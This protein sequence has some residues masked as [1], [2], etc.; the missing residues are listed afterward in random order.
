MSGEVG[1]YGAKL[2]RGLEMI[3]E[4]GDILMQ[5]TGLID[6]NGKQAWEGDI[7][8]V[9]YYEKGKLRDYV[10]EVRYIET[11]GAFCF[12]QQH[13]IG[14]GRGRMYAV[15]NAVPWEIIGNIYEHPNL[16]SV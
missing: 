15:H 7:A 5:F 8:R 13:S 2:N 16:L 6:K 11:E 14:S 9:S 1:L 10:A 4:Q 12:Y 3:S